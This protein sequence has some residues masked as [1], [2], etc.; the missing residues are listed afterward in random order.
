MRLTYIYEYIY[1]WIC[2]DN[3]ITISNH[4]HN[5]TNKFLRSIF[6][7]RYRNMNFIY[8]DINI[9]IQTIIF[10]LY[11]IYKYLYVYVWW[12]TM[13]FVHRIM[14]IKMPM[15]Y[16]LDAGGITWGYWQGLLM[17]KSRIESE[18]LRTKFAHVSRL[19]RW[20]PKFRKN[21]SFR[22][23]PFC[24]INSL[25]V[26]IHLEKGWSFYWLSCIKFQSLW[27]ILLQTKG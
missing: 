27:K 11:F 1:I 5:F 23:P 20:I 6:M 16:F 21:K 2:K 3:Y 26:P 25:R 12:F 8:S 13:G 24:S 7:Y 22:L 9:C 17:C 14:E 4:L 18:G 10:G 15:I 19:G